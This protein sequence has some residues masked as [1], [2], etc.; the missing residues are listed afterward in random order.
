[1]NNKLLE[2]LQVLQKSRGDTSAFA[3]HDEFLPW[4]DNVSPLLEFDEALF[5]NFTFW[6]EHVKSAHAMGRE[7]HEALGEA[8]GVVNQAITKLEL[9]PE[10]KLNKKKTLTEELNYPN[11]VTLKWLYHHVPWS[12]WAWFVGLL[13]SVFVL[14]L[15]VAETPIYK[16]L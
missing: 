13:I 6:V 5:K 1:M 14:G 2:R 10:L 11:K 8:I 12:F 9:Q 7:H 15:S 16:S 3:N 4:S